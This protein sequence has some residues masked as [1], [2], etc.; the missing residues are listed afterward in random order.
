MINS[1]KKISGGQAAV[2]ALKREKT[3]KVVDFIG[4]ETEERLDTQKD[5]KE[6]K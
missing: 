1:K 6:R 2:R 4:Y 5:A 3:K